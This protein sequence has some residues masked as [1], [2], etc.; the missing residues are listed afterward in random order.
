MEETAKQTETFENDSLKVS[1]NQDPGCQVTFHIEVS[2]KGTGAAYKKAVKSVNKQ[3]SLPGFRKGKAPDDVVLKHYKKYVDEEWQEVLLQT[4]FKESMALTQV[5][6]LNEKSIKKP[7]VK[8][9]SKDEGAQLIIQF[10]ASPKVPD[11][12]PKQ[13][14]L[15]DIEKK[16]V[17]EERIENEL[18]RIQ[19]SQTTW[20]DISDRTVEK[21]DAVT[22]KVMDEAGKTLFEG[23]KVF[24]RENDM[25]PWLIDQ[26]IGMKPD[27]SKVGSYNEAP[28]TIHLEGAFTSTPA[29]LD[30]ALAQ[31]I[32]AKDLEDLTL[33]VKERLEKLE[34]GRVLDGKRE[35]LRQW[36][37]KTYS[38]DIPASMMQSEKSTRL[39]YFKRQ[40][41]KSEED[42]KEQEA[43]I[44]AFS[45]RLDTEV[46][47]D[48]KLYFIAQKVAETEKI[49]VTKGEMM[50][51]LTYQ[52][53]NP[54]S[55]IDRSTD[56]DE[57]HSRAY[58]AVL[59]HKVLNH[60]VDLAKTV[61]D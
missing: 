42:A 6:P 58:L 28:C 45:E 10:E 9:A 12:D 59:T 32:G 49:G 21:G 38:F 5:F 37:L 22:I 50:Q 4:A 39:A 43:Q 60:L 8:K 27:E 1:V 19:E 24:V 31:K 57:A 41:Q 34:E 61:S 17:T 44:A 16:P 47:D 40:L 54:Y 15:P 46:S 33:K 36:I 13:C 25:E 56:A 52:M 23:T 14:S 51:E 29:T 11:I 7:Q 30:D 55:L 48:F 26:V 20:E 3:V 35:A 18:K 53:M 2:P